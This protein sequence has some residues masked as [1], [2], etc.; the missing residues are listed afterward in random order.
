MPKC[1]FQNASIASVRACGPSKSE[2]GGIRT[3]FPARPFLLQVPTEV[4]VMDVAVLFICLV[5][6]GEDRWIVLRQM[7]NG[8]TVAQP[9]VKVGADGVFIPIER[10]RQALELFE[11]GNVIGVAGDDLL[12]LAWI[13][14][15]LHIRG[16]GAGQTG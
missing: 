6:H 15:A 2:A 14:R 11:R 1:F 7:R 13:V 4:R 9:G 3:R 16:Q 8:R 12:D 5:V 10:L